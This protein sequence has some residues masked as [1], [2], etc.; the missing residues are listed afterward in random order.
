M[1]ISALT[2]ASSFVSLGAM[3]SHPLLRLVGSLPPHLK[4][5][6]VAAISFALVW[7]LSSVLLLALAGYGALLRSRNAEQRARLLKTLDID[8]KDALGRRRTAGFFH[9]YW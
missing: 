7:I 6:T 5:V 8:E 3:P 2:P 9:P 4:V 1:R